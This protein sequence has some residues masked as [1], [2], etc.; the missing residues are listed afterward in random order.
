VPVIFH[1]TTRDA[2]QA[3]RTAGVYSADSLATEGFIHCSQADQVEWVANTRFKGRTDLVLL[4][5]DEARVGARVEREN[6]EGGAWLFPHVYG[7]LPVGAVVSMTPMV[8]KSDGTFDL[9]RS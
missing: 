4:R 7:A 1:I 3:A 5:I 8:P 6:L 9:F 2:W